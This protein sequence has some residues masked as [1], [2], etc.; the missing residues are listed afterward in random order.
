MLSSTF[1]HFPGTRTIG[2]VAAKD[3]EGKKKVGKNLDF[4]GNMWTMLEWWK[5][6]KE[7]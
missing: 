3:E 7:K 4:D 6:Y 5:K 1:P 2:E